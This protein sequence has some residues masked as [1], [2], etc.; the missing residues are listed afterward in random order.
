[1]DDEIR[2]KAGLVSAQ[3]KPVTP[4]EP[5]LRA[6]VVPLRVRGSQSRS[7]RVWTAARVGTD[8]AA[9]MLAVAVTGVAG[10]EGLGLAWT[11]GTVAVCLLAFVSF[12]LYVPRPRRRLAEELR[13]ALSVTALASIAGAGAALL[14]DPSRS[15][16]GD[17]AIVFCLV[18]GG[19]VTAGRAALFA[20]ERFARRSG[21]TGSR[22]LIVGAG[23]VGM[24]TASRLL[25][26][27]SLGMRPIGFL[28]KEPLGQTADPHVSDLQLPVLG[29]SWDL[30]QVVAEHQVDQ[31]VIA[32]S[33]AP[34]EV[35]LDLVRRCWGLR[36]GVLVVPRLFE[37]EG[38]R[39]EVQRL[40]AVPLVALRSSDPRGAAVSVKYAVDRA[41]AAIALLALA[42]L[43][44][45]IAL[46]VLVTAG[47]PVLFRQ[48]RMGRDGRLFEILKF[49]TMRGVPD[50]DGDNN[51]H[52]AELT[53]ARAGR[54]RD[55]ALGERAAPMTD[56]PRSARSFATGRST[57]CPS[58]GTSCAATCRS[59]GRARR[60]RT[61][62]SCSKAR[63][64]VTRT[65][66]ASSPG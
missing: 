33:T 53:L 9:L 4:I 41:V 30:E 38:V 54:D 14:L 23:K 36:V 6:N 10:A 47:R 28:D 55:D 35:L 49:R 26:D 16:A 31:V 59:S 51:H 27:P 24:L 37:V 46:A 29:A 63:S 22:T 56:A 3:L 50:Q 48:K 8:V 62:Q 18:A 2:S 61:T 58:S 19:L 17:A 65:G 57:S 64:R 66:T 44:G 45:L 42:P 5:A 25:G 15:G 34:N 32:F 20:G 13:T 12:G 1:M 11:L 60:W 21:R 7:E 39:A 52:W 43:L 40:G